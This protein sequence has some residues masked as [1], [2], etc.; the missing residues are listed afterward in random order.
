MMQLLSSTSVLVTRPSYGKPS[1][2]CELCE[3]CSIL[4]K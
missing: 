1:Q 4:L 3:L 2:R